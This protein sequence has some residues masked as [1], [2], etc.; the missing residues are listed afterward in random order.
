[1]PPTGRRERRPDQ[2]ASTSPQDPAVHRTGSAAGLLPGRPGIHR[3]IAEALRCRLDGRRS[4]PPPRSRRCAPC[5][6]TLW[7]PSW[8]PRNA[9]CSPAT[10]WPKKKPAPRHLP[11]KSLRD[12]ELDPSRLHRGRGLRHRRPGVRRRGADHSRSRSARSPQRTT[13]PARRWCSTT[14]ATPTTPSISD[15]RSGRRPPWTGWSP[16]PPFPTSRACSRAP[17]QEEPR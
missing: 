12:L 11:A 17:Q 2:A 16:W 13:S 1:M 4:R 6:S 7:G 5:W 9:T 8:R 3:L 15:L 10:S 14:S